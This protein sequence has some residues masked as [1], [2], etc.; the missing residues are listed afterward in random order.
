VKRVAF[1]LLT[2]AACDDTGSYPFRARPLD[3]PR[4]CLGPAAVLD[5]LSGNDPGLGCSPRCFVA[6]QPDDSGALTAYGTTQCGPSPG[7]YDG[8]ET[9]VRCAIVK[10]AMDRT[11]LCTD[12]GGQTAPPDASDG[13]AADVSTE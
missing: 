10:S 5:I 3:D 2:L 11:D 6:S 13:A 1:A 9:D 4:G 12:D 7:G 8:Q